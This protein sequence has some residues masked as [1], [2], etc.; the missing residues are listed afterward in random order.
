MENS[1]K[2]KHR[3]DILSAANAARWDLG[4]NFH[5]TVIESIFEDASCIARKTVRQKGEK[6]AYSIDLKIDR[7]VTSKW[8]GFP[9]MF[10]LLGIVFWI[11]VAGANYPSAL[12]SSLLIDRIH[13]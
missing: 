11:T 10:L 5:D 3:E 2:N 1:I 9:I 13:P 7:I 6:R 4:L 8:L 12:L